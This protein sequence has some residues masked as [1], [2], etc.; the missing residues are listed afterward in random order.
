M[1]SLTREEVC[2]PTRLEV[3][4][5]S[6][7]RNRQTGNI[8]TNL[9]LVIRKGFKARLFQA[10]AALEGREG[11]S[12]SRQEIGKRLGKVLGTRPVKQSTVASWF[13]E[14]LP[15]ADIGAGIARVYQVSAGWLYFDERVESASDNGRPGGTGLPKEGDVT[16]PV[17]LSGAAKRRQG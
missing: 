9:Q 1:A 2:I 17:V 4:G 14:I 8:L 6:S 16:R 5:F 12:I 11:K 13:A 3:S 15:P 7:Q 10:H